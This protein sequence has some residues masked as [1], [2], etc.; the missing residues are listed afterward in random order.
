M[1]EMIYSLG[2]YEGT[3]QVLTGS[4]GDESLFHKPT[5]GQKTPH[6]RLQF[7]RS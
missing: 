5:T 6:T 7:A 4:L 1:R 3:R 2:I